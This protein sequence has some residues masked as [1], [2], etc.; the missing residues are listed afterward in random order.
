[1]ALDVAIHGSRSSLKRRLISGG[2]LVGKRR[3]AIFARDRFA[4]FVH[5]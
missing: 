1:M 5:A 2:F 3:S 4:L